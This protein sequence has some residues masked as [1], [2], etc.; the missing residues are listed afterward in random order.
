M[1]AIRSHAARRALLRVLF[2]AQVALVLL[3]VRNW[4]Y[5]TTYRFYLDQRIHPV[6]ESTATQRFDVENGRVVPQI[7]ARDR[8][9]VSF[10]AAV[11]RPS[12][13][14]VDVRP[15]DHVRYE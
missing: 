3:V 9:R 4:F 2:I 12:T 1:L 8:D 7:A 10:T 15:L 13:L 14:H 11:G 5:V 6:T